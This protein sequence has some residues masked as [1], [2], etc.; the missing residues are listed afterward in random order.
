M[1][2][3][4][5]K[6]TNTEIESLVVV[7]GSVPYEDNTSSLAKIYNYLDDNCIISNH[8]RYNIRYAA[9]YEGTTV[10]KI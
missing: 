10:C 9:K 1:N 8:I 2:E 6:L 4:I 7:C 5:L 3:Y